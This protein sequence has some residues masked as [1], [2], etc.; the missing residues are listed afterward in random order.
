MS[1]LLALLVFGCLIFIHELG[2]FLTAR[3]FSVGVL[4]FSIGM[5]PK[6]FSHQSKKS[7]TVYS[8]RLFPI[9]GYVSMYGEDG[10]GL[11]EQAEQ[12]TQAQYDFPPEASF[13]SKKTWQKMIITVAGAVMNLVFGFLCM[14]ILVLSQPKNANG[15]TLY[16]TTTVAAFVS[17]ESSSQASGLQVGDEI[18]EINGHN[19]HVLNDLYY[20]I[21]LDGAEVCEVT[22]LRNGVKQTLAVQ[23]PKNASDPRFGDLDFKVLGEEKSFGVVMKQTYHQSMGNITLVLESVKGL[24]TGRYGLDAM[25]GPVGITGEIG[26]AASAGWRTLLSFLV[27][28]SMN[29]G[30]CNLLP[31]PALDGGRL[32]FLAIELVRRKPMNPKYEGYI[33]LAGFALLMLLII[34]VTYQDI[35]R[36]ATG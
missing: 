7:Q 17:Q 23:F 20:R 9:G 30:V 6:I 10:Q 11:D 24:I 3:M 19:V 13:A 33:H 25:S 12:T 15:Q 29:L 31:I 16:G 22:V 8:I 32:L 36:L 21:M 2:H 4:E 28:I 34:V 26:Q 35:V 18:L 14:M 1:I 5:G 27:L